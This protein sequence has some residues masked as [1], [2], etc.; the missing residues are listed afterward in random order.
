MSIIAKKVSDGL[1][2]FIEISNKGG[3]IL[4]K[5]ENS[6]LECKITHKYD[7]LEYIVYPNSEEVLI[8]LDSINNKFSKSVTS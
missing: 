1:S 5:S 2:C 7:E 3:V 6:S 4:S 8:T